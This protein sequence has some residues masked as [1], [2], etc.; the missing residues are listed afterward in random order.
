MLLNK[1]YQFSQLSQMT[2][3]Y[4]KEIFNQRI[5]FSEKVNTP[6]L[7]PKEKDVLIFSPCESVFVYVGALR[8]YQQF[9]SQVTGQFPVCLD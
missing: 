6:Y 3:Q 1:K 4:T 9:A 8:P 7:P 2:F 5:S